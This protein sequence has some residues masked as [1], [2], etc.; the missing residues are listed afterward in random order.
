VSVNRQKKCS[1]CTN[2]NY[3]FYGC[4]FGF[5]CKFINIP[6]LPIPP[7]KIPSIYIDLSHIDA[8]IDIALPE[9]HFV[10]TTIT[11]PDLPDLPQ[12]PPILA[13]FDI[14]T[15]KDILLAL[16]EQLAGIL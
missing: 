9:F 11:L 15:Q 5:I 3:N 16:I 8:S 12:V 1:T 4:G 2:D 7:F 13:N 10:P 14:N 6:I